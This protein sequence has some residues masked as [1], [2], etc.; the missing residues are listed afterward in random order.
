M[1][2]SKQS[3]GIS[4]SNAATK[5]PK[6]KNSKKFWLWVILV[7]ALTFGGLSIW[8]VMSEKNNPPKVEKLPDNYRF[9]SLQPG[10]IPEGFAQELLPDVHANIL[11]GEDTTDTTG[12]SQKIVEYTTISSPDQSLD[13]YKDAMPKLGWK[14][15]R[16]IGSGVSRTAIFSS[17]K[18][19]NAEL[20]VTVIPFDEKQSQVKVNLL[21][22]PAAQ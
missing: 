20:Q 22:K 13:I 14:L 18:D 21:A 16:Q 9:A 12:T 19:K 5:I 7:L 6:S 2:N 1:E 11:R 10:Y 4:I 17:E 3:S 15:D 8:K